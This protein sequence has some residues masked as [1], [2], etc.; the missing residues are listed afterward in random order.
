M[1][2]DAEQAR[3]VKVQRYTS[4]PPLERSEDPLVYWTTHKAIYPNLYKL[5][6]EYL[7]TSASSVPCERVFS[8]AWEIYIFFKRNRLKLSTLE[9]LL[10]LNKNA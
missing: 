3:A 5:A 10:F 2:Q 4:V 1:D 7:A 9:K 8:K 6:K